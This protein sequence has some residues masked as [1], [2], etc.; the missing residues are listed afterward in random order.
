MSEPA[1]LPECPKCGRA[2][3][4]ADAKGLCP[5]CLI[6]AALADGALADVLPATARRAALP[7][8]FGSYEL[9]AEIARGGMGIVYR[10]RQ[11]QADR[12]V[13]V[14]VLA[15]G[16]FAAPDFVERFHTEA[17]AVASLDHPNIVP[18]YEVGECEGQPFFSMKLVEGGSL[19]QRRKERSRSRTVISN[20]SGEGAQKSPATD[21]LITDSLP[22]D[23]S[24]PSIARL[25]ATLARAIHYAHQRGILHRDIKPGNVLL[26]AQGEP[27]LTDF[28]LAKLVENEST[29]TH[30]MAMLGTPSYMSPEQ[31]RGEAKQLTTAVDVYGLGAVFYELLAGQPPFAGGTTM[32]TVRLVLDGEPRRP[33]A[34]RA[35]TDRDLE[36][37]CLKCLEKEPARRYGSAEA[38]A[39]DLER[40]LRHEPITARPVSA[41]ETAAKW[42][43]RH[44]W[45]SAGISFLVVL[46][47]AIAGV[48]VAFNLRLKKERDRAETAR[49]DAQAQRATAES[50]ARTAESEKEN[51]RQ[52]LARAQTALAEA[53]YSEEDVPAMNAALAAVPDDRRDSAWHY[54][55]ARAD[56]SQATWETPFVGAAADPTRPGVFAVAELGGIAVIEASS[57][58]MLRKLAVTQRQRVAQYFR[59]LAISP[60][61]KLLAV[62]SLIRAG[63]ALYRLEDGSLVTQWD[64]PETDLI[65]FSKEGQRLLQSS[66]DGMICL[67]ETS[68]GRLV[69]K[70]E[71]S[72]R[73]IFHPTTGDIIANHKGN[74]VLL[75]ADDG[76]VLRTLCPL[77]TGITA[78]A[79]QPGGPLIIV[80]DREGVIRS[81]HVEDGRVG[82]ERR[83]HDG[84]VRFL[85][86]TADGGRLVSVGDA[87]HQRQSI[88][89][90]DAASGTRLQT[91]LRGSGKTECLRVHPLTDDLLV[92]G[93]QSKSWALKRP[94]P[95]WE[96]P[97][98][99]L[100][101]FFGG[102]SSYLGG[103][104]GGVAWFGLDPA[105][106]RTHWTQTRTGHLAHASS[107]NGLVGTVTQVGN[108]S[109][110]TV[111]LRPRGNGIDEMPPLTTVAAMGLVRLSASGDRLL[112]FV[113]GGNCNG[114]FDTRTGASLPA[115]EHR[116]EIMMIY[117]IAWLGETHAVGT[118]TAV[119]H[120]GQPNS[121]ERIVLWDAAT[122]K[123]QRFAR[124]DSLLK[125]LTAAPDGRR[126]AEAGDNKMIRLRDA[127]TL[128]V[129]KE[130][131][132][133]DAAITS[134]AW[135]PTRAMLASASADLTIKL[136]DADT[137]RPLEE[138]RGPV[139]PVSALHFSPGGT[140]LLSAGEDQTRVWEPAALQTEESVRAAAK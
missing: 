11:T 10:A 18:I 33:S 21:P 41:W 19:A 13:A 45:R 135:H 138:L 9:L 23:Y 72:F 71:S 20:Q 127:T 12:V 17:R 126:F 102:E 66:G 35:D 76:R 125:C 83:A 42:I 123:I 14:K 107:A 26:D 89:V 29:L 116:R 130:F 90:W 24:P 48:S 84:L 104:P 110:R 56:T 134:L 49:N 99:T 114:N 54:L 32:E 34:L 88:S 140:R 70:L 75:D 85:D 112:T 8:P 94:R 69:W 87:K 58:K 57:G 1:Q 108:L 44:P 118:V 92:T 7:R 47:F 96:L 2:L 98:G 4:L 119:E 120:R 121:E 73:A 27:H 46:L 101:C 100:S 105:G 80:G 25:I 106:L 62:G 53:A 137:G 60:D 30:T 52:A 31:A 63:I 131:R 103:V 93:P 59:G 39:E 91:V 136:W 51:T 68:T 111:I 64:A 5:K 109:S 113:A 3:P 95:R 128:A 117:D 129:Q 78:L 36:I 67:W 82:F 79:A 81:L 65:E 38:V 37:I 61:G 55:A 74:L 50:H 115:L 15:S 43:R 124:H 97:P 77:R 86:F 122:G 6:K 139:K 28:G 133:H 132:A 22:T 40:W 16:Q